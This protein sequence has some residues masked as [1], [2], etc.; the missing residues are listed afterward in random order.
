M[1]VDARS[2]PSPLAPGLLRHV[3]L[4]GKAAAE[5][6]VPAAG[7]S[8]LA[9][10]I[11]AAA[12]RLGFVRA[13]FA[14]VERFDQAAERLA[15]WLAQGHQG[16]MTHLQGSVDRANPTAL[17][18]EAQSIIAVALPIPTLASTEPT[19][20]AAE[21]QTDPQGAI[22]GTIARH[23]GGEDY[24]TVIK[25]KLRALGQAIAQIAGRPI[26]ARA[27]VDSAP[28]LEREAARVAGVGFVG[29]NTMMIVPGVGSYVL[30]GELLVDLRVEPDAPLQRDCGNCTICLDACPTGAL[31]APYQLDARRCVSYL[32][33]E[34]GGAIPPDLRSAIGTR[35]Y[36]CDT[37]QSCCP[38]NAQPDGVS[39]AEQLRARPWAEAPDLLHLLRLGSSQF[40]RLVKG[41]ALRRT[42]RQQ[43]LRNAAIALG[44]TGDQRAVE[45]LIGVLGSHPSSLVRQH[46]A[47][48]LGCLGGTRAAA[49]LQAAVS[50]D[51]DRRVREEAGQA[52]A[53]SAAC[54]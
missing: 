15:H 49:S 5:L 3:P 36:G 45:P 28:L 48:A 24:H 26:L 43:L 44:N 53:A 30:L 4:P 33:I 14:R 8:E 50:C 29:K 40:R 42:G 6:S 22:T 47:W 51:G 1:T 20:R 16:D 23:A 27:C 17:H 39:G 19:A 38:M 2:A 31:L 41:T 37:C 52:L 32:T 21:Q 7:P 12:C 13:G 9:A 54:V 11:R 10:R 18:P 46:A 35:V 34:L 25:R